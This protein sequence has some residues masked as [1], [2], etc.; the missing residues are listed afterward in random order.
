[1]LSKKGRDL[2]Y[3]DLLDLNDRISKL[4][5]FPA[6]GWIYTFG[7]IKDIF[8]NQSIQRHFC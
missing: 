6:I 1:M 3:K 8:D 5:V 2:L 4:H 7:I